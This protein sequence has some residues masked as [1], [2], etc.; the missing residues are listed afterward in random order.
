MKI[1]LNIRE[2]KYTKIIFIVGRLN[3]ANFHMLKKKKKNLC[4]SR[5][6][7]YFTAYILLHI[8]QLSFTES[9]KSLSIRKLDIIEMIYLLDDNQYPQI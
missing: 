8:P 1:T 9:L 2:A 7:F 4:Y 3:Y 5:Y 6:C